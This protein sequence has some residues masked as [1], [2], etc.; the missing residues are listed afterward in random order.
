VISAPYPGCIAFIKR[1]FLEV[2]FL[3][4]SLWLVLGGAKCGNL[5]VVVFAIR[6]CDVIA[7]SSFGGTVSSFIMCGNL[8]HLRALLAVILVNVLKLCCVC[9]LAFSVGRQGQFRSIGSHILDMCRFGMHQR[10]LGLFGIGKTAPNANADF[11]SVKP[12]FG[13][14]CVDANYFKMALVVVPGHFWLA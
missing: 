7:A 10:F 1:A 3:M 6:K 4:H 2:C 14:P 11:A 5:E 13:M 9:V 12:S 8:Q